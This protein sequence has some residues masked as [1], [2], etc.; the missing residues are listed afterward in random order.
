MR[1]KLIETRGPNSSNRYLFSGRASMIACEVNIEAMRTCILAPVHSGLFL[2]SRSRQFSMYSRINNGAL[3]EIARELRIN[4]MQWKSVMK[5]A[6]IAMKAHKKFMGLIRDAPR[7]RFHSIGFA[8]KCL[9]KYW[10]VRLG[11]MRCYAATGWILVDAIA[12]GS[13]HRGSD[14]PL[15]A[16][17]R[18]E[19]VAWQALNRGAPPDDAAVMRHAGRF[20][21]LALNLFTKRAVLEGLRARP[22]SRFPISS[23]KSAAAHSDRAKSPVAMLIDQASQLR[24]DLKLIWAGLEFNCRGL[25]EEIAVRSKTSIIDVMYLFRK[26]EMVAAIEGRPVPIGR[27]LARRREGFCFFGGSGTAPRF[28]SKKIDVHALARRAERG[29]LQGIGCRGRGNGLGSV[30]GIARVVD[31][32]CGQSKLKGMSAL[33]PGEILVTNMLQ[34]NEMLLASRAAGVVTDE[35]G[36]SSHALLLA[37]DL[38]LPCVVG[39]DPRPTRVLVTGQQLFLDS[40][41]GL[42][43]PDGRHDSHISLASYS[44]KPKRAAIFQ[45]APDPGIL[46]T[47][48]GCGGRK[49]ITLVE[50]R[51]HKASCVGGK[52][53]N[54]SFAKCR[55]NIPNGIVVSSWAYRDARTSRN[56][57]AGVPDS[58]CISEIDHWC[59]K[60]PTKR[61]A[62]RSS[63]VWEDCVGAS[64]AGLQKSV[65][66]NFSKKVVEKAISQCWRSCEGMHHLVS[67]VLHS[68]I[69]CLIQEYVA[70]ECSG[71]AWVLGGT[72]SSPRIELEVVPGEAQFLDARLS[73]GQLEWYSANYTPGR[74]WQVC[75]GGREKFNFR[76]R[77]RFLASILNSALAV[78]RQHENP[79]VVE[80]TLRSG[81]VFV[82][83]V[84]PV[85][86][87]CDF[88]LD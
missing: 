12:E 14:G 19:I 62:I 65:V 47:P 37:G 48:C 81:A 7:K 25:F 72:G 28:L 87:R 75:V 39:G 17:M 66:V 67:P 86:P 59:M 43:I 24:T 2:L 77:L 63:A 41:M 56:G 69:A 73:A 9:E 68:N 82:L 76:K 45:M 35:G 84:R 49:V 54:L 64:H 5:Q 27:E 30:W 16:E 80:W 52:A 70:G 31:P 44:K 50:A 83:Q 18:R 79:V 53:L 22:S 21:W 60:L 33:R 15:H 13:G 61:I 74:G 8:K 26:R 71:T 40:D 23:E 6:K 55:V 58:K 78:A 85:L 32:T 34:P 38:R 10:L 36:I 29:T 46:A 4:Q 57:G 1:I 51:L 11:L 20:P 42:V 88:K 3:N